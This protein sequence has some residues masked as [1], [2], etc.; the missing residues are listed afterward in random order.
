MKRERYSRAVPVCAA[1]DQPPTNAERKALAV[2]SGVLTSN[3]LQN[4]PM[5]VVTLSTSEGSLGQPVPPFTAHAISVSLPKWKDNVDYEE[6]D[7]RVMNAMVNGY[8]RFFIGLN[9]QKV[10]YLSFLYIE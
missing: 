5:S 10:R 6:G 4:T 1:R 3:R 7:S 2:D 9:I 8:P